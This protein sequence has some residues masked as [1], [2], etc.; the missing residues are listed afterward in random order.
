M[1]Q[2]PKTWILQ[3]AVNAEKKSYHRGVTKGILIKL[4]EK[5]SNE[6]SKLAKGEDEIVTEKLFKK[7]FL[8]AKFDK[9][10]T[11]PEIM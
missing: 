11:L 9:N 10:I 8:N 5:L 4:S 7:S 1:F 3:L 2:V 6:L